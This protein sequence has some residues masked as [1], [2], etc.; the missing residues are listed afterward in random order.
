MR[1]LIYPCLLGTLE[2]FSN[3][4]LSVLWFRFITIRV[5]WADA[6]ALFAAES[7]TIPT[8]QQI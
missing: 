3:M 8:S 4:S 2:S 1:A 6:H 7:P 5:V